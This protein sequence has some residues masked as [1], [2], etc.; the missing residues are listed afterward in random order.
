MEGLNYIKDVFID[1]SALDVEIL[2]QPSLMM[3][4]CIHAAEK[5]REFDNVKQIVEVIKAELDLKIREKPETFGITKLTEGAISSVITTDERYSNIYAEYLTAKYE[6]NMANKAVKAIEQKKESLE[7]LVKLHGQSYFAGPK[8]P[9]NLKEE[10]E[11]RNKKIEN[12]SKITR[13]K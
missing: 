10:R 5:E 4:Y 11:M 7:L 2:E 6:S 8:V 1:D 9:H 13:N 3:K 12:E